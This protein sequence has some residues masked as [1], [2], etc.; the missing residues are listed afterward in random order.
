MKR[1]R[2]CASPGIRRAFTVSKCYVLNQN[3]GR[4]VPEHQKQPP[5]LT[6][7]SPQVARTS[8]SKEGFLMTVSSRAQHYQLEVRGG[9]FFDNHG[10]ENED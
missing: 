8:G 6:E 9:Q 1:E 3:H 4:C 2:D 5:F 10:A 7:I